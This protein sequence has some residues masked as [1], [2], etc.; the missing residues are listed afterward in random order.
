MINNIEERIFI[1]R[2]FKGLI[3]ALVI[4][5]ILVVVNYICSSKGIEINAVAEGTIAAVGAML[6]Y[7]GLTKEKKKD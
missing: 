1:M 6:I 7:G 5:A 3:V 2:I 4:L